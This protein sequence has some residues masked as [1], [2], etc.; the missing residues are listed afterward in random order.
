R[1]GTDNRT[2]TDFCPVTHDGAEFTEP[3]GNHA[4]FALNAYFFAV[5]SY[6]GKNDSGPEVS[7]VTNHRIP[8]AVEMWYLAII[9][10]DAVFDLARISEDDAITDNHVFADIAAASDLAVVSD[11]CRPF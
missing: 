8:D 9:E 2:T 4:G 6:V 10:N 7:F 3:R 1:S 5:Q 11:P